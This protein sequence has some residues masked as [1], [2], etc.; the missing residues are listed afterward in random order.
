VVLAALRRLTLLVLLASGVTAAGSLLLGVLL[1]SSLDRT[2]SLGF[3]L[4]GCFLI[5]AGFFVGNRGPARVKSESPGAGM[6]PFAMFGA[7]RLRWAT[8]TEQ[9]EA[10]NN[11]AVFVGLGLILILIGFGFDARHSLL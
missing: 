9:T 5:L 1:G 2:L 11:S 7:R 4:V 3:Y 6:L 10:I 8:P